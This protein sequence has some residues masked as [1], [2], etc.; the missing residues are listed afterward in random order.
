MKELTEYEK[1]CFLEGKCPD[2]GS[3]KFYEGPSGGS[4]T[5][6]EC[7]GE[8]GVFGCGHK[9]NL[10]FFSDYIIGQRIDDSSSRDSNPN[11]KLKNDS[12]WNRI[13]GWLI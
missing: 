1:K 5:N 4:S 9:F 6:W 10:C 12:L 2:C 8:N 11:I 13:K 3:T 7:A